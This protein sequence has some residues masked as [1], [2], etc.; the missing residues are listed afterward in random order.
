MPLR[1]SGKKV[2]ERMLVLNITPAELSKRSSLSP[3]TIDRITNDRA[4]S[5]SNYTVKRLAD[6]LNCE[7]FELFTE[8]AVKEAI[9]EALS[10]AVENVVAE[11]V[12]EAV[13][14]VVDEVAPDTPAQT[15][16]ENVPTMT[17][18]VPPALDI[19][20][21]IDHIIT[22]HEQEIE[23]LVSSND[24]HIRELQKE[25]RAWQA[26]AAVLALAVFVCTFFHMR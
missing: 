18:N 7:T 14:V 1:L 21:Y 26:I 8:E 25:K 20:T 9:N 2:K 22:K 3:S 24:A 17:V 10:M 23:K 16:A 6:A 11:A 12:T 19:P 4:N 13:T 5:Y 15:V